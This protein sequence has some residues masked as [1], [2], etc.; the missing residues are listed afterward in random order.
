MALRNIFGKAAKTGELLFHAAGI[1]EIIDFIKN[2]AKNK[3]VQGKAIE[4]IKQKL[5]GKGLDDENLF[6]SALVDAEEEEPSLASKFTLI[7]KVM[8]E[9]RLEDEKDGTKYARNARLIVL[10]GD[11][12]MM[13]FNDNFLEIWLY[14]FSIF[15]YTM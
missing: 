3:D 8:G 4:V 7:R 1:K 2:L 5:D 6:E 11:K 10:L 12:F 14:C 9:L 15:I 13:L